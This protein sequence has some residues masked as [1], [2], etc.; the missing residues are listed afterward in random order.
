MRATVARP[1]SSRDV[2]R[3]EQVRDWVNEEALP[4]LRQARA[5]LNAES[6]VATA[7]STGGT[8]VYTAVVTSDA[9]PADSAWLVEA[10]VLGRSATTRAA[11]VLRALVYNTG[12]AAQQGA[13]QVDYS[14]ESAAAMDARIV[15]SGQTV[16]VEVRDAGVD[17]TD[18]SAVARVLQET[19]A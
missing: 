7:I 14:E 8:G 5:A 17:T 4:V 11:Y 15:V 16:V 19:L 1:V 2:L 9:M 10:R 18:W 13:T 6:V 12:V 3:D